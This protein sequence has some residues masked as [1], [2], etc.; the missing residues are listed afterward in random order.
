[1]P[2]QEGG[3][4]IPTPMNSLR[5]LGDKSTVILLKGRCQMIDGNETGVDFSNLTTATIFD[6]LERLLDG[7]SAILLAE[8]SNS[9]RARS[10]LIHSGFS[11]GSGM[12]LLALS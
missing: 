3:G 7:V 9:K 6:Q 11:L 5:G 1:M 4:I 12:S 8:P 2:S 10:G